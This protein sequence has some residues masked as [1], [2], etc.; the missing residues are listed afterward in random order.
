MMLK[1]LFSNFRCIKYIRTNV[2]FA[3]ASNKATVTVNGPKS[4][5]VTA[6]ER[7]VNTNKANKI[8]K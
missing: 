8:K 2:D 7:K 1:N 3:V 5:P 6:T 4:K